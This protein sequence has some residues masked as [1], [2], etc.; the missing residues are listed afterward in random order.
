M[1][2]AIVILRPVPRPTAGCRQ[3]RSIWYLRRLLGYR[4]W[5]GSIPWFMMLQDPCRGGP[6][7]PVVRRALAIGCLL[8]LALGIQSWGTKGR[9]G[10]C[11]HHQVQCRSVQDTA[12][13]SIS[14]SLSS[15]LSARWDL[16]VSQQDKLLACF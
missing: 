2:S 8:I 5:F 11:Q 3:A 10:S 14:L 12:C 15:H 6:G 16:A 7:C 4:C 1:V 9:E 13:S